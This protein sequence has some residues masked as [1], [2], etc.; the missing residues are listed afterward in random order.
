MKNIKIMIITIILL[1]QIFPL[2]KTNVYASYLSDVSFTPLIAATLLYELEPFIPDMRYE[3]VYKGPEEYNVKND[4]LLSWPIHYWFLE[5]TSH[6]TF[7]ISIFIEPQYAVSNK[8]QNLILGSRMTFPSWEDSKN[9][10][11]LDLGGITGNHGGNGGII[12][13]G[14]G[15][16][17]F[18]NLRFGAI[19]RATI[20]DKGIRGDVSPDFFAIRR[21]R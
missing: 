1:M 16:A 13:L 15:W 9:F 6:P 21:W 10:L 5:G 2:K 8:S 14:L 18:R 3:R 7:N 12:G 11:I 20:T 17:L 19:F 4:L